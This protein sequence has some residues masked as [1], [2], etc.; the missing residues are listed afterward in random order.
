M[1]QTILL[2]LAGTTLLACGE[3]KAQTTASK[4]FVLSDTMQHMIAIDSVT[5]RN[6]SDEITLSG[7]VSFNENTVVKIF[8]RGSGQVLQAPVSPGDYVHKG[9]VLATIRSADVA[10]NFSDLSSADADVAI[11]RRQMESAQSLYKNGISSEREYTEARQNYEKTLAVRHKIQ[12]LIH[13]NGGA[14]SNA[15]GQ[16]TLIAPI[17]GYIVEKKVAAGSFIRSD[18]ADNLFTIS[19]LKQV[20]VNANVY[21]SDI[22]RVREGYPVQVKALAYP[23]QVFAGKVDKMGQVLDPQSKA[24][25]ARITI[26]NA[27]LLLKP[28]MFVKVTVSGD[29]GDLATC[30]PTSALVA[31]DGRSYVVVYRA[32]DD[33]KIAEVSVLKAGESRTFVRSG[34]QPGQ[35]VVTRFQNL[36]FSQLQGE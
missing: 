2:L 1:K 19:D 14:G 8:P 13:I 4:K 26:D 31:Q 34:V 5:T 21:E 30:V 18:A 23:D 20:W 24:L 33:L 36:I 16:Y 25:K 7:E 22:A 6:M 11:A 10:G 17:D 29:R 12:S 15:S 9:Q 35:R 28:D 27:G 32:A 3:K